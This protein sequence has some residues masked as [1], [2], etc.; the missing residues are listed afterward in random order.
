[1]DLHLEHLEVPTVLHEV[2]STAQPLFEKNSNQ[3]E[4]HI[5][6]HVGEMHADVTKVKQVLFNLLTNAANYTHEGKNRVNASEA[7]R[8]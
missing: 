7:Q 6:T 2:I 8:E 3:C 4:M 5:D 1:M